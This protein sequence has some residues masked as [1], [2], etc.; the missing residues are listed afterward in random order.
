MEAALDGDLAR[1]STDLCGGDWE[2]ELRTTDGRCEEFK[3]RPSLTVEDLL[4]KNYGVSASRAQRSTVYLGGI[5]LDPEDTLADSG[6]CD[7]ARLTVELASGRTPT[8]VVYDAG[9]WQNRMGFAGQET[10]T[11]DMTSRRFTLQFYF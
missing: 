9:S 2:L 6:I 3:A 7:G 1:V 10:V 5:A 4:L 11:L 8:H